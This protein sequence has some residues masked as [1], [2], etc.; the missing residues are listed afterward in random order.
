MGSGNSNKKG[1]IVLVMSL[2]IITSLPSIIN[3]YR[4]SRVDGIV[5]W[6]HPAINLEYTKLIPDKWYTV[7]PITYYFMGCY[8]RE[9][10]LPI[11][12]R[13]SLIFIILLELVFGAYVYWRSYENNFVN[14]PWSEYYSL[15]VLVLAALVFDLF[16]KLDYSK[17]PEW[18]KKMFKFVSGLSLGIYLLSS[19]FDNMFYAV[20][21]SKMSYSVSFQILTDFLRKGTD[22]CI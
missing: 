18:L 12:K 17:I 15:F 7:Y 9:Y 22:I 16:F 1:K 13:T 6:L 14:G 8:L 4:F 5:W 19:I 20:L 10:K 2:I 11:K 21:N 3:V